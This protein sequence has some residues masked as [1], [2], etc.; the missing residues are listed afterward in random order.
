MKVQIRCR[1]V[2]AP[3]VFAD[4][5]SVAVAFTRARFGLLDEQLLQKTR[6]RA[7]DELRAVAGMKAFFPRTPPPQDSRDPLVHLP[8]RMPMITPQYSSTSVRARQVLNKT[9]VFPRP[10]DIKV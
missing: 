8:P 6:D 4:H 3:H 10:A 1:D 7:V 2:A 9:A 5:Q